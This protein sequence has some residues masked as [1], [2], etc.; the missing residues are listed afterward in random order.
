MEPSDLLAPPGLHTESVGPIPGGAVRSLSN[1]QQWMQAVIVH[2]DGIHVGAQSAANPLA[3]RGNFASEIIAID[4]MILPS[5]QLTSQQR[6]DVYANA[7]YARLLE[8]LRDEYPALVLLLGEETF[9][10][11]AFDYL[12]CHPSQSYT[13][14]DL[15]RHF[16]A[17]LRD[18][19]ASASDEEAAAD[20]SEESCP[21]EYWLALMTDLALLERTYSEVFSGPGIEDQQPLS[22]DDISSIPPERISDLKL[23]PSPCVRL[24]KLNTQAHDYAIAV[25][26]GTASNDALPQQKTTYL[27]VTRLNYVVRTI[28]V[29][30]QEYELLEQL[31]ADVCLGE[32]IARVADVTLIP[33]SLADEQDWTRRISEWF[34]KWATDRLFIGI[35]EFA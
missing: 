32:A 27:V 23:I 29:E 16:P 17:F 6:M 7:Y 21:D 31:L 11:F 22:A 34:Q 26:K 18:N 13:L 9:N 24:L 10:A 8:C 5:K 35:R 28:E 4:A 12:Q 33:D 25:R 2:P 19:Q 20:S 15:G 14:A 30:P 1:I 3:Q